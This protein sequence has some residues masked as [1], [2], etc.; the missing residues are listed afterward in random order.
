MCTVFL[1]PFY[2]TKNEILLGYIMIMINC[3]NP[4]REAQSACPAVELM[5][6]AVQLQ[7][8]SAEL[9][10]GYTLL[11][12]MQQLTNILQEK[13]KTSAA[14]S[15]W[16]NCVAFWDI[17]SDQAANRI[18]LLLAWSRNWKHA[19][20]HTTHTREQRG[21]KLNKIT[22]QWRKSQPSKREQQMLS[23]LQN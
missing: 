3:W 9:H 6:T 21:M 7:M 18:I 17:Q 23:T 19:L 8:L 16:A 13:S 10:Q 14:S 1:F 11:L 12:L 5:Q 4:K 15:L 22:V 20:G 2:L